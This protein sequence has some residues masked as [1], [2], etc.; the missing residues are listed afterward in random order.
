LILV[1][2]KGA[3]ATEEI[4]MSDAAMEAVFDHFHARRRRDLV[5]IEAGLDPDVVH[6]G[7]LP[8]LVCNG[9]RAV[10]ERMGASLGDSHSDS[11]SGIERLELNAAGDCVI[12][13]IAGPRFREIPFLDGEIFM[14][15]TVRNGRI[16]R[17]DDY[18]TREE[19]F[20]AVEATAPEP[21]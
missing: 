7:V 2:L 13:G 11:D 4:A 15:F 9:R 21:G 10:L 8:D 12:A 16:L 3:A 18:R 20:R 19:A 6:Q 5:A 17:I 1:D 14:V